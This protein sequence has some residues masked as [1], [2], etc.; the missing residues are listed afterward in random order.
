MGLTYREFE[1]IE[2]YCIAN[3]ISRNALGLLAAER[4]ADRKALGVVRYDAT[5]RR[6]DKNFVL[7]VWPSLHSEVSVVVDT[8]NKRLKTSETIGSAIRGEM[9]ELIQPKHLKL[10][11]AKIQDA[12]ERVIA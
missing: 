2:Q 12:D 1:L 8:A 3:D 10:V 5:P 9:L 4:I 6:A 7:K 11:M